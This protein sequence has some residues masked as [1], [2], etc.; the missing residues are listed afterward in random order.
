MPD[1]PSVRC[2]P[3]STRR[4]PTTAD[5]EKTH[6]HVFRGSATRSK[7]LA[8]EVAADGITSNIV[9]PGRIATTRVGEL[10]AA[11]QGAAFPM[12]RLTAMLVA[13]VENLLSVSGAQMALPCI[14]LDHRNTGNE[15]PTQPTSV[16]MHMHHYAGKRAH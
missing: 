6:T 1:G 3:S 7:T 14:H 8:R 5:A 2:S 16:V 13:C 15:P 9:V 10:D 12:R 11:P 4:A